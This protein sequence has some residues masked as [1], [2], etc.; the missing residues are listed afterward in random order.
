SER[1]AAVA[2]AGFLFWREFRKSLPDL[3]KIKHRVVA[4]AATAPEVVEDHPLRYPS[5]RGKSSAVAGGSDHAHKPSRT[6]LRWDTSESP[7]DSRVIGI[8]VGILAG[9]MRLVRCITCGMHAWSAVERVDLQSRVVRQHNFARGGKA[10][11]LSL[12]ASVLF[13][14]QAV[15][16]HGTQAGEVRHRSD[17]DA[18]RR[19][20][21]GEIAKLTRV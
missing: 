18:M 19:S 17:L 7:Q 2:V 3:R 20:G 4:E 14:S 15:F 9:L 8:V 12:L 1:R 6:F 5:E 10:V 11:L 21:A 16:N 13:K